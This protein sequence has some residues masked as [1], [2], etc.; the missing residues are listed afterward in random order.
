MKVEI[1]NISGWSC[2]FADDGRHGGYVVAVKPGD[3]AIVYA[4]DG[5]YSGTGYVFNPLT[6]HGEE[7]DGLFGESSV[8]VRRDLVRIRM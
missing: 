1:R 5:T 4:S 2:L 6:C 3:G 8:E 7:Q